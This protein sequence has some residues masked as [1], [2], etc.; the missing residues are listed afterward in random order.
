[1]PNRNRTVLVLSDSDLRIL[2]ECLGTLIA[3][4]E[5]YGEEEK[6]KK[7]GASD[8]YVSK[9]VAC[10]TLMDKLAAALDCQ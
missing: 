2:C 6:A 9:A 1:M 7:S 8:F 5:R 10:H 3:Q 4:Y